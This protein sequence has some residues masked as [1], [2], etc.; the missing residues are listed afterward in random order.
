[1][2]SIVF[3]ILGS[4]LGLVLLTAQ[5][6]CA[7][8]ETCS[9]S[10]QAAELAYANGRYDAAQAL[11]DELVSAREFSSLNTDELCRLALL[12]VR[13]SEN[14]G[15]E[16]A[17]TAFAAKTLEATIE[18]DADSTALFLSL[19]PVEDQARLTLIRAISEGRRNPVS[20]DSLEFDPAD[21]ILSY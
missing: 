9:N 1:M 21:T 6:S 12:F 16:N 13:L 19:A 14:H 10:L 4:L 20:T 18:R 7:T 11:C 15:D 17:N 2:K 5:V 3:I 8:H